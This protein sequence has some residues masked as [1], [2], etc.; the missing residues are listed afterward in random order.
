MNAPDT[1]VAKSG[2][3]PG[4]PALAARLRH[5]LEGE[6]LFDAFTRGRYSTDASIYQAEPVGVVVPRITSYNVCYTK[7]LRNRDA[8]LAH[9]NPWRW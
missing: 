1:P 6:V 4:D 9:W 7:L 5:E 8:E 3:T 2:A